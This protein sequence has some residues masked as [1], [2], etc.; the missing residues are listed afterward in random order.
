MNR[1]QF[2][3]LLVLVLLIGGAGLWMFR[4]DVASWGTREAKTGERLFPG[5]IAADVAKIAMRGAKGAVTIVREGDHWTV[6]E[7]SSYPADVREITDLLAKLT[8]LK[9]VQ[10]Q[11]VTEAQWPRLELADP[12]KGDGAGV[13]LE[14]TGKDGKPLGSLVAGKTYLKKDPLNPLP[15]AQDGV[16]AGRYVRVPAYPQVAITVADPLAAVEINPGRWLAKEFIRVDRV[17]T[18]TVAPADG[19]AWKVTREEEFMPWR[20]AGADRFNVPAAMQAAQALS[21]MTLAD[22]AP[23]MKGDALAKPL[24]ITAE[25]FDGLTYTLR[26]APKDAEHYYLSYSIAGEPAKERKPE[27]G[28]KS[29]ERE[30]LDKAWAQSQERLAARLKFERMLQGLVFIVPK[31]SVAALLRERFEMVPPA[32]PAGR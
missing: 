9:V 14:L 30:R 28:E 10:T 32:R 26:L 11:T 24:V 18:L 6:A 25:T 8:E 23:G 19:P 21:G 15:S 20:M 16:P 12:G 5:L 1:K 13:A 2:L 31:S 29:E 4:S 17:R 7:R 3:V 22:V 27:K